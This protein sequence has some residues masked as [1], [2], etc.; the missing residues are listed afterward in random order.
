[1]KKLYI[2]FFSICA[3]FS[4]QAQISKGKL[5]WFSFL[6]NYYSQSGEMRVYITSET[7]CSGTISS[8]LQGWF[9]NFTVTPGVSTQIVVPHN[10]GENFDDD[11]ISDKAIRIATTECVSVFAHWYQTYTSDAA[12][13]FPVNS[14]G[15]EYIIQA[16]YNPSMNNG[17]S[18]FAIIG[19]ENNTQ[20]QIT[21]PI[22]ENG[23]I[24]GVPYTIFLDSGQ[25]YQLQSHVDLTGTRI[26]GLNNKN[27]AVMAGHVCANVGNCGYC[28][29]LYEQMYPLSSWGTEFITVPYATRDYDI[30][31]IVAQQNGTQVTINGGA[32]INLNAGQVHQYSSSVVSLIT[33]NKPISVV[34]YST[35]SDCDANMDPYGDPFM[36]VLSPTSQ[37]I[38]QVT[39]TAFPNPDPQFTYYVN[40]IAKTNDLGALTFDGGNIAGSFLPVSQNPAYSYARL[41][42]TQGDH[43]ISAPQGVV[44]YVYG[45]GPYESYG[46]AAGVRVQ[47]PFL[48]VYDTSKLYCPNDTVKLSLNTPDTS[49]IIYIEWD[50]GDGSPHVFNTFHVTH[51]YPNYGEYPIRIIYELESACKKDTAV[52]DTVKI[53][54]PNVYIQ[55]P[56]QFCAP[57]NS[58]TYTY[59]S[60]F[61]LTGV[62]WSTGSTANS[63][64]ISAPHDT[65]LTI[66][67]QNATCYGYDTARIYVASDTAGFT[68][69]NTCLG[70]ATV[71]TNTSKLMPGVYYT[72]Q[73]NFG[74]GSPPSA[75]ISPTHTYSAA[76]TYQVKLKYTSSIGCTDSIIRTVTITAKPT[77][78][79]SFTHVCND[80]IFSPLNTSTISGG[81]M[82][83]AWNFG[84]GS[85]VNTQQN[86]QHEYAQSGL[87]NV[88]L[89]ASSAP[90]CADTFARFVNVIIG[91]DLN[92]AG[93]SVCLGS[94]TQ[95]TNL[96]VNN[97]GSA[98]LDYKWYFGDG[99]SSTALNPVHTYL[100]SGTYN[101][102]LTANYGSS[103]TE[104]IVKPITVHP[105]P[106]AQFTV[107]DVCNSGTVQPVNTSTISNGTM[108]YSWNFGDGSAPATGNAPAH[109][110]QQS[111]N[112]TITLIA[113]SNASC[114][115]TA[116]ATVNVI[117]GTLIDFSAPP[118]CEG[119]TTIF[120]NQTT[121]PYNTNILSY[122]W[123]FGDGNTSQAQN[124]SHTY[125]SGGTYNVKLVL[126]YGNNCADSLT[127]PVTV[128]HKPAANFT[129]ADVCN[130]G[131]VQ[132]VNTSTISNGTMT[133]SWNFGDGSAPATGNAPA[134]TYQQSGNYTITLIATSNASCKDTASATVN[135]IRGT[136]IDFSAPP[137]CEGN[138]TIFTNQTTNPYNTNIL[139]YTW[140]FGDGNTSQAQNPSHT[141]AS[142]GTYNVKLVLNYGNNCADSLTKPVTVN[143]KPA[144]NFTVADVCNSGTVQ[145]V[146]TS[147]ISNG[148]MT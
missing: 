104:S 126:N 121:N 56:T 39:F 107:A 138:T 122:T 12:V 83:Y 102:T 77:A 5:F 67:G 146:N 80:S 20:I 45:Y 52:I 19:T 17:N 73:W 62:I 11:Q 98:V 120:T 135:V 40:V 81:S 99:D 46:Y 113:T 137:V 89:I 119:N 118:V 96:T 49:R 90:G 1:M 8:P 97:S 105:R 106:D 129:V 87:Y 127:K 48:S 100:N 37:T 14:I 15:R 30:F 28:D 131:T 78:S 94:S 42:I 68:F 26:V 41:T 65:I 71:F 74:D 29:M 58:V 69:N 115:D 6:Q 114:K 140:N 101:V 57:Q 66:I 136:L 141:Y 116:S 25:V 54:G 13:I 144:A 64:T 51:V 134:H 112:Y 23:H 63:V 123:N 60:Q 34:Q 109:T 139:S 21:L 142:G 3:F 36:I 43:T 59:T 50:L 103:C 55:G 31:R 24:A 10:I 22:N 35:G 132:P 70:N 93:T 82:T 18:Q 117:R 53:R 86:P 27:F 16:W 92:F 76:G 124:P 147:T 111:G 33:S 47:I 125:A 75:A 38:N 7:P 44:A 110:Y 148:T 79:F 128:N 85:P 61:P 88:Q 32:P 145:P 2:V 9:Q 4:L 91:A 130:S 133:Y 72:W 143:H 108:T 95:F 84:D